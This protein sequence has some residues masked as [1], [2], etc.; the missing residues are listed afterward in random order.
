[1]YDPGSTRGW[2]AKLDFGY[3]FQPVTFE[4]GHHYTTLVASARRARVPMPFPMRIVKVVRTPFEA[5][6]TS[7]RL[8]PLGFTGT[9]ALGS[10]PDRLGRM[11]LTS[12]AVA[13]DWMSNPS[14]VNETDAD[15]CP[16][17]SSYGGPS[18]GTANN[19][20][21]VN[22][23]YESGNGLG[24]TQQLTVG[25]GFDHSVPAEFVSGFVVHTPIP[26]DAVTLVAFAMDPA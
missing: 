7:R 25:E 10:M 4:P 22:A 8:S 16:S 21:Y 19:V 18:C 20:R 5:A 23:T 2:P 26:F 3:D 24:S 12:T 15:A 6:A 14:P 11:P 13:I 9:A 1:M 17:S